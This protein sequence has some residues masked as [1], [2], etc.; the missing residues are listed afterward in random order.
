VTTV[1]ATTLSKHG[2][3]LA[4]GHV[5]EAG[6]RIYKLDIGDQGSTAYGNGRGAW[7]CQACAAGLDGPEAE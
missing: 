6:D 5:A 1:V 2:G 4:C 7:V 3:R